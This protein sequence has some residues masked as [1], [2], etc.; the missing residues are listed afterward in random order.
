MSFEPARGATDG[1]VTIRV[2]SS[3]LPAVDY[4]STFTVRVTSS[5]VVSMGV[6]PGGFGSVTLA[7]L[8]RPLTLAGSVAQRIDGTGLLYPPVPLH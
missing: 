7:F 1:S 6:R 3:T 4:D 2:M 5:T 8:D